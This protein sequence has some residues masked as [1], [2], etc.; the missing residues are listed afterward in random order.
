MTSKSSDKLVLHAVNMKNLNRKQRAA[1]SDPS[2][3]QRQF[4]L[5]T[6]SVQNGSGPVTETDISAALSPPR[7]LHR[8]PR[9]PAAVMPHIS[10]SE[11]AMYRMKCC[12]GD[13]L[14][15]G[16]GNAGPTKTP[17]D[18]Y[19]S[20]FSKALISRGSVTMRWPARKSYLTDVPKNASVTEHRRNT[21]QT[22][23]SQ[24]ILDITFA[25]QNNHHRVARF[26]EKV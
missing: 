2:G 9:L 24:L 7:P 1:Q 26:L 19:D 12:F 4:S 20:F 8:F 6:G 15:I 17:K 13:L 5:Q 3:F 18:Y 11:T 22:F 25:K 16:H 23:V 21:L 10:L 14:N